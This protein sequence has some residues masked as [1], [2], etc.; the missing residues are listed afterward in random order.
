MPLYVYLLPLPVGSK[1]SP[2][3]AGMLPRI[4][5]AGGLQLVRQENHF[6]TGTVIQFV[7][8]IGWCERLCNGLL[9]LGLSGSS[10]T[11]PFRLTFSPNPNRIALAFRPCA[12]NLGILGR[13]GQ[14]KF[15]L[16]FLLFLRLF[17][18]NR[19]QDNWRKI[20]IGQGDTMNF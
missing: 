8:K 3:C 4:D 5:E 12:G 11:V 14:F 20:D 16:F 9:R 6:G 2:P 7:L 18:L 17:L 15:F 10:D 1:L 13:D 19:A